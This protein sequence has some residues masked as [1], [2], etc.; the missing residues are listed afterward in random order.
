[1]IELRIARGARP[2]G[3]LLLEL[4]RERGV[5]VGTDVANPEAIVSY[6]VPLGKVAVPSLNANAG[7]RTKFQ[8]LTMLREAQILV[9][10]FTEDGRGLTLPLL[11]R[12]LKHAKGQDIVLV[13]QNGEWFDRLRNNQVCNFFTQFIPKDREFRVYAYRRRVLAVYEKLLRYPHRDRGLNVIWNWGSGYA[14]EFCQDAPNAVKEIGARAV[15]TMGLD[16]GAVDIIQGQDNQFYTLEVNSA[17][18]V[19]DRRQGITVLADKITKWKALGFPRRNG[20]RE[21]EQAV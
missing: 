12:K 3:Q 13:L 21:Q 18:G 5:E 16:F 6:G 4:L 11:G 9:P 19:Q 20:D 2:T 17:P 1:M 15:N 14:F 8:E 7:R 10:P